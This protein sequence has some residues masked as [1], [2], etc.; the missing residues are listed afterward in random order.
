MIEN[1]KPKLIIGFI[2]YG[3]ATAP[4]LPYFL[5]SL[6]K[7]CT[8]CKILVIDNTEKEDNDNAKYIKSNYP[9]ID[10]SWA[11]SNLGFAQ[12]YN[13][14]IS[15][16]VAEKAEYFLMINPDMLLE[17]GC[18]NKLT[19]IMD[20]NKFLGSAS[21]KVLRWDF[22]NNQKTKMIDTCGIQMKPGLRFIDLG[23]S[24]M[25]KGQ[26]DLHPIL[27]PSGCAGLYRLS[28]LEDIKIEGKYF[29]ELFFMYKEDVDLSYRLHLA[30]WKSELISQAIIY[31]DR[32]ASG[33]G[34]SI[35]NII[36]SRKLKSQKVKQWSFFG[37][38][39]LFYKFW[40]LQNLWQKINIISY[41]LKMYVFILIFERYLFDEFKKIKKIKQII[42]EKRKLIKVK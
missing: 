12:A 17:D 24:Q 21:P 34:E 5:P 26:F 19:E 37:Q 25:D 38:Q 13:L 22:A 30:G 2:T 41:Q 11:G 20:R 9:E 33:K 8:E 32:T 28:A 18:L 4:Y 27:G 3:Q 29:D 14:I 1:N 39:I 7:Q 31:H 40:P 16:A 35:F 15:Q 23:Q 10:F 36:F 6:I 42:K